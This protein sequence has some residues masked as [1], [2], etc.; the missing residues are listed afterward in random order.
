[1]F[2]DPRLWNTAAL[3]SVRRTSERADQISK[4]KQTGPGAKGK[5]VPM[6]LFAHEVHLSSTTAVV[7][8]P[9][10]VLVIVKVWRA[11]AGQ[12][13]K[14]RGIAQRQIRT[15]L[16]TVLPR[17]EEASW[18]GDDAVG[19]NVGLTAR[20]RARGQESCAPG[21]ASSN[22]VVVAGARTA[23]GGGCSVRGRR[24]TV[25]RSPSRAVGRGSVR[26]SVSTVRLTT[27]DRP[28]LV[29]TSSVVV[30]VAC[31]TV[32]GRGS[33]VVGGDGRRGSGVVGGRRDGGGGGVGR[34][35]RL[36]G[37]RRRVVGCTV[38]L[39]TGDSPSTLGTSRIVGGRRSRCVGRGRGRLVRGRGH[40]V[41]G[42]RSGIVVGC[43]TADGPR[44]VGTSCSVVVR[45]GGIVVGPVGRRRSSVGGGGRVG[46][47]CHLVRRG[48]GSAVGVGSSVVVDGGGI[49]S[50]V[51]CTVSLSAADRP[52]AVRTS[53][54]VVVGTGGI[55][56][57]AGCVV[58]C[59][60]AVV[61]VGCVGGRRVGVV[62]GGRSR[63][64]SRG[65][66][67]VTVGVSSRIRRSVV[68]GGGVVVGRGRTGN[69]QSERGGAQDQDEEGG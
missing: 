45:A 5:H 21:R 7:F 19:G 44:L 65:R 12:R 23:S 32:R 42:G 27:T 56:V 43:T 46:G 2:A 40:L 64:V 18:D 3:S 1:M 51:G 39:T 29:G 30:V 16:A 50:V 9:L 28:S 36:V 11:R 53:R 48:C 14:P 25:G 52:N 22:T 67:S 68:V 60:G 54:S 13:K 41:R 35:G 4:R 63:L 47:G 62:V 8:S 17:A 58:G 6:S 61:V 15:D 55:V 57:G 26:G 37:G 33:G 24:G 66:R 69:G 38:I 34:R 49:S 31:S 10:A 59:R 20:S